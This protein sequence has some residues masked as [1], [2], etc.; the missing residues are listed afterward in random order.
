MSTITFYGSSDDLVE[1][2]G[3]EGADEF[4]VY[5]TIWR[6]E[7]KAPDD[8][9]LQVFASYDGSWGFGVSQLDENAPIPSWPLSFGTHANGYSVLLNIEAPDGTVLRYEHP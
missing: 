6:A 9:G 2:D 1:V 5:D 7:L 8:S 3:C 4:N